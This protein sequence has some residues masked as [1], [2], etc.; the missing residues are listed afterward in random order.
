MLKGLF[1]MTRVIVVV[2]HPRQMPLVLK[3][4]TPQ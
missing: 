1:Q 3:M 2:A 4:A